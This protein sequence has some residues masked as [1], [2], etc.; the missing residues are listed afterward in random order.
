MS[1][2]D[3]RKMGR[4]YCQTEG[5]AHYVKIRET[6]GID[7][8]EIAMA[9]GIFED[10]AITNMVKYALRFKHTRSLEDL[11]KVSDYSHI[12]AGVELQKQKEVK[13]VEVVRSCE[14]CGDKCGVA[15][16]SIG[17]LFNSFSCWK[18]ISK[19]EVSVGV[20]DGCWKEGNCDEPCEKWHEKYG[21]TPVRGCQ[22]CD[23]ASSN[24]SSGCTMS[25]ELII[26][27][28]TSNYSHWKPKRG[29]TV[30]VRPEVT[31]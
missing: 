29:A 2:D 25:S 20:C 10:F 7:A 13:Q 15:H 3:V 14:N 21:H 26:E 28:R 5:S 12:L 24:F 6:K 1:I 27:C 30:C 23:Y 4:E 11:K 17:S 8:I 18:P 9:N 22:T 16:T 19:Q 31:E